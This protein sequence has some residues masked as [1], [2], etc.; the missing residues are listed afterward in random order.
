MVVSHETPEGTVSFSLDL[1][2]GEME[3]AP[4]RGEALDR[5]GNT[6]L[7]CDPNDYEKLYVHTS[8]GTAILRCDTAEYVRL[9]NEQHLLLQDYDPRSGTLYDLSGKF[10]SHYEFPESESAKDSV[11][12]VSGPVWS[13][14][15]DGY[16]LLV[17]TAEA[18]ALYLWNIEAEVELLP[19]L[20]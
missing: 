14:A 2:T 5:I 12:N 18:C 6:W 17:N 4:V 13:E 11:T 15:A 3:E 7:L 1:Y 19:D 16:Y 8:E 10:L 9:M 20:T